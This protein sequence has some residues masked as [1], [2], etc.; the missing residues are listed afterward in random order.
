MGT[1]HILEALQQVNSPC[2]AV[3]ITSDK[4]YDNLE[5]TWGYRETDALGGKDP[6]SASKGG[7]ELAI[8]TY[9]HSFF[10]TPQSKIKIGVGRAGNVI[11]GAD[12]ATDRIVPDCMRAWS[13]NQVVEI[14]RPNATRPWQ[15]VLEPLSGYL[16][17]GEYL[18][19]EVQ[20]HGEPYN[21]GPNT[22]QNFSV[23]ELIHEMLPH[24]E[25]AQWK[26][27]S[28]PHAP[29]EATLLKLCCDKA[30]HQLAWSPVLNFQETAKMTVEWY[31]TFYENPH[32]DMYQYSIHQI[33]E[34]TELA[35]QRGIQWAQ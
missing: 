3:M 15:H 8:K 17:L 23:Q 14:R 21:F 13:Q 22:N 4:S 18:Q 32:T 10:N 24:W 33:E 12:W 35:K 26:D 25:G 1:A 9:F 34:F 5:W 16:V 31:R 19:K 11:G 30:L 7:A 28:D 6:Y 20:I 27:T 29:H 2:I